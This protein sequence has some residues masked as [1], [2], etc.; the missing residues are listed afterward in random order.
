[1]A[2]NTVQ[3]HRQERNSKTYEKRTAHINKLFKK[4]KNFPVFDVVKALSTFSHPP[5]EP[6]ALHTG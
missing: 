5:P 1:M 3:R 6:D 2:D 4:L